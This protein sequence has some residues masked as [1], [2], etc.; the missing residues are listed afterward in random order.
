MNFG[1]DNMTSE[2]FKKGLKIRTE[3]LGEA[4][5]QKA[6]ASMDDFNRPLQELVT[7]YCW[8]AIWGR[9]GLKRSERS[10]INLA[11]IS[12]LNRPHELKA[13]IRG[14]LTNGLKR[15]QICEV[16]LQ[17]AIYVGVPAAVDSFRIA[18]ETFAEIDAG[19]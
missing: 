10:M 12:A 3:V 17:V 9:D 11:M 13:H 2:L 7:E 6:L 18:R 14:A 4:Y 8:G 5:V 16:F 15:E 19:G 1:D